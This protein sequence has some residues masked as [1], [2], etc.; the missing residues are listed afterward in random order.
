M[1]WVPITCRKV[2]RNSECKLNATCD[3]HDGRPQS[4]GRQLT[5]SK[6]T[7]LLLRRHQTRWH[8]RGMARMCA[9]L[10]TRDVVQEGGTRRYACTID[11]QR[12]WAVHVASAVG[13]QQQR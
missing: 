8:V 10:L 1:I 7:C 11:K 5:L 12:A 13:G 6:H 4:A 9:R 2:D 3:S